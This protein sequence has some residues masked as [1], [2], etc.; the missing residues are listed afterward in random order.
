MPNHIATNPQTGEVVFLDDKGQWSPAQTAI[1]PQTKEMLAFDGKGWTP[2]PA[3]KGT[4]DTIEQAAK[5]LATPA[6]GDI[7][8]KDVPKTAWKN[9]PE[10]TVQFAKDIAQPFIHPIDTAEAIGNIGKGVLQKIGIL[11]GKDAEQYADAVGQFF[12]DRYGSEDGIKKA[13]ATDPVGILSD[14]ATVLT[15]GGAAAVR[16]PGVVG[17]V[18]HIASTAGKVIDP[19]T[20]AGIA[21]KAAGSGAAELIGGLGTHTGG[22]ALMEAASAGAEGGERGRALRENMRGTAALDEA[23]SDAKGAVTQLRSQ[24]GNEYRAAMAK[25]GQDQAVLDFNKIDQAIQD[26]QNVKKYKGQDLSPTTKTIRQD[27]AKTIK[28]WKAL[29]PTEFHTAEGLDALKQKIGDIR[30]GTKY[31]SPERVVAD[32][33]YNAIKQTIIDQAPDYAKVM[34]GYEEAS[35]LVQDIEKTLSLNPKAG[36]DTSLRKLQSVLRNNVSANFGQRAKLADYL[37]AAGAKNLLTKLAGQSLNAWTPRG[38][39]KIVGGGAAAA[40]I[41]GLVGGASG[42]GL[43]ALGVIPFTSPR[44]MGEAAHFVG[45]LSPA[46]PAIGRS[47]FQTGRAERVSGQ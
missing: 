4:F 32:R 40:G 19:L 17:K 30:D 43:G 6:T 38:L 20:P 18:G 22:K 45:R 8:W 15:G 35:K 5:T 10:S 24:R 39:G 14:V 29:D 21:V 9:A 23:V 27:I 33:S 7:S 37:V 31:G 36:V 16:A 12:V 3:S 47:A 46:A 28:K 2:V 25:I 11:S 42:I 44:L 1:N 34:K 41:G 26:T 13:I